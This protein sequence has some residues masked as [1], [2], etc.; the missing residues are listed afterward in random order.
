MQ[1]GTTVMLSITCKSGLSCHNSGV[2]TVTRKTTKDA[3]YISNMAV[4]TSNNF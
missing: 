2:M 1:D 3:N 4:V